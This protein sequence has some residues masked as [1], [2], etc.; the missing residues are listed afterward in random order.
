MLALAGPDYLPG[1][2][3]SGAAEVTSACCRC[4]AETCM[5][6]LFCHGS[7]AL[8]AQSRTKSIVHSPAMGQA[9]SWK[10]AGLSLA[11]PREACSNALRALWKRHGVSLLLWPSAPGQPTWRF[12]GKCWL[13]MCFRRAIK[14]MP[15]CVQQSIADAICS[16][17]RKPQAVP[18]RPHG[19]RRPSAGPCFM[20]NLAT[21]PDMQW[22]QE[23][24]HQATLVCQH[25]RCGKGFPAI[26][27]AVWKEVSMLP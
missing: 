7:A 15:A 4:G 21:C 9:D 3:S 24:G 19:L 1:C 18:G 12:P 2:K 26:A 23:H 11:E 13:P 8:L 20:A 16:C 6:F 10:L 27:A 17:C 25:L 5:P 22:A 14:R